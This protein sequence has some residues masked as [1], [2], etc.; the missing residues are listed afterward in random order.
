M[1]MG[2][3]VGDEGENRRED[4]G[5]GNIEAEGASALAWRCSP[6]DPG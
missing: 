6:R 5:C 4:E 2:R 3:V 1:S